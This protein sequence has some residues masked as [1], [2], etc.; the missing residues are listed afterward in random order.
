MSKLNTYRQPDGLLPMVVLIVL[1][2]L[3]EA[4]FPGNFFSSFSSIYHHNILLLEFFWP[5]G[6][7]QPAAAAH[8]TEI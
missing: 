3:L 1:L 7:D 4:V 2:N 6:A 8:L 5:I